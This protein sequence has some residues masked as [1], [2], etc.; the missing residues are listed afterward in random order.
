M[1]KLFNSSLPLL[2]FLYPPSVSHTTI[3]SIK[4][5]PTTTRSTKTG[6]PSYRPRTIPPA[7][8]S[9]SPQKSPP[10]ARR[11]TS[12][13]TPFPISTIIQGRPNAVP[14]QRSLFCYIKPTVYPLPRLAHEVKATPRIPRGKSWWFLE[15]HEDTKGGGR[16]QYA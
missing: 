4:Q 1:S 5:I 10:Q 16:P 6:D 2:P 14:V 3:R 9:S 15:N 12:S 11:P 7:N 8:R 13:K